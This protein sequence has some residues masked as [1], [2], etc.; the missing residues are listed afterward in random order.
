MKFKDIKKFPFSGYTVNVGWDYLRAWLND[1]NEGIMR[2]EL[3]PLYQRGYVW[4]TR[5]KIE[6]V[7]YI[8]KGGF[9]GRDIFWNCPTWM[10]FNKTMNIVELVDGKQRVQAVL[11]FLDNKI[12]AFNTLCKDYED[13]IFGHA[14]FIFH[15]NNL[16][17]L[18]DTVE[19]YIGFNTGGSVHTKKDLEPAY[20]LLKG[21]IK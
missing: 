16:K 6:Y 4:S 3:N 19:W 14:D 1:N 21:D 10:P 7:E 11:D 5:Q 8:L 13:S 17:S 18:K 15:V 2:L 12:P 9:S 20:N